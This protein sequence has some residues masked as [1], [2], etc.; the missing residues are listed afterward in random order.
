MLHA[1]I[2]ITGK[3]TDEKGAPLN[4]ASITLKGTKIST[5]SD[6]N[7]FYSI[8]VPDEKAILVFTSVG[9]DAQ[10]I[11]VKANKVITSI[12]NIPVSIELNRLV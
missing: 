4:G 2:T 10:E 3:I 7:G 5:V 8:Q 1:Q 12:T 6:V 11:K 9:L